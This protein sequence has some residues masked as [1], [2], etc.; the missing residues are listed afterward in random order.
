MP[1]DRGTLEDLV[2]TVD[3]QALDSLA[4]KAG[5]Q[6]SMIVSARQLID[7]GRI[8]PEARVKLVASLRALQVNSEVRSSLFDAV[9]NP[10]PRTPPKTEEELFAERVRAKTKD[11]W[12]K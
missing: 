1:R 8:T 5:M 3:D 12:G 9:Q 7:E 11:R 2:A 10:A 4:R 6:M